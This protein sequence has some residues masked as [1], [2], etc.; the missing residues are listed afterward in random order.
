M[1]FDRSR[2]DRIG[3]PSGV[4]AGRGHGTAASRVVPGEPELVAAV[5]LVGHEVDQLEWLERPGTRAR[6]RAGIIDPVVGRELARLDE[7][8]VAA[9]E[10][11]PDVDQRDERPTRPT[12]Q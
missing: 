2:S 9:G 4:A 5:V 7:R 1:G 11:R 8:G 6:R 3:R 10:Q 12:I